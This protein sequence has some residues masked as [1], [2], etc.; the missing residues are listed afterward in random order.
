MF[1]KPMKIYYLLFKVAYS[2]HYKNSLNWRQ[3]FKGPEFEYCSGMK[4]IDTILPLYAETIK[5][6]KMIFPSLNFDC[7]VKPGPNYIAN[8]TS[9]TLD[10]KNTDA[11]MK[12]MYGISFPNGVY[13][14][15]LKIYTKTDPMVYMFTYY[16]EHRERLGDETF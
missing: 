10:V 7:P 15:T 9:E 14:Q 1:S 2:M 3:L 16:I 11:I 13:R 5:Y 12:S 8:Y 4:F 6:F